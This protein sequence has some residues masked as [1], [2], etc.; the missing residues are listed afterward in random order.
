MKISPYL[1]SSFITFSM[2]IAVFSKCSA[3]TLERAAIAAHQDQLQNL[4]IYCDE[5]RSYDVNPAW[6]AQEATNFRQP[7]IDLN[8]TETASLKFMFLSGNAYYDRETDARTLSY[9]AT[10]GLPAIASQ[11][12]TI[13]STG[14]IEE[15][16]QQRLAN[17]KRPRFG[18]LRQLSEF[19]PEITI[20][21]AMGLRLLGGR[22]WLTKDDLTSMQEIQS[23]DSRFVVLRAL[24][25]GGHVHELRYDKQLLYALVYYRCTNTQGTSLE[26]ANSDFHQYGSVFVPDKIVRTSNIMD[27]KGQVRHPLVFTFNVKDASINDPSNTPDLYSIAWPAHL[28]LFDSRTNDRIEVGPTTRPFSDEDIREQLA[29]KR[30][31]KLMLEKMAA[32]RIQRV[33]ENQPTTRP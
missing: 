17:G 12:Q 15:L 22:Q 21:I 32:D 8:R 16:T 11:I 33:L 20:D 27:S 19:S 4:I 13:T 31:R 28:Q 24:D 2:M 10:K 25:G 5:S 9:W 29:E 6:A 3:D 26:I 23:A 1:F 7:R 30:V 14:R 18:G